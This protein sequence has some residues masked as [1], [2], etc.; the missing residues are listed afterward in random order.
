MNIAFRKMESRDKAEVL[1][2]MKTFYASPAVYTSGS[3][4]IFLNDFNSC[5]G[6]SPFLEGYIFEADGCV[7]GYSMLAKS[8]STEFGKP[9]IWVEDIY[10]KEPYRGCGIGN[11]FF[12]FL[13]REYTDVLFRLEV[14]RENTPAV[15][16]YTSKGY[17]V[18]P[19]VEMKK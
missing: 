3:D 12:D 10:I 8:F 7:C 16:L 11:S 17:S 14:E 4:E 2:M 5:I 19:Y 1:A 6:A 9:C 13:A 18:L 15:N